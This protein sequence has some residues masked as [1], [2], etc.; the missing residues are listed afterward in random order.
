[1]ERPCIVSPSDAADESP[2]SGTASWI[3]RL[4]PVAV[5]ALGLAAFFLS[6]AHRLISFDAI[7]INYARLAEWV[8]DQPV[9]S[10]LAAVII[11]ATATAFSVPAA[12]L[13]SV[14]TGLVF[15]WIWGA[16]LV[17]L[18]AT[19]GATLLFLA[20]GHAFAD[21]FKARAGGWIDRMAK[22]FRDDAV[23]YMLFLRLAPVVPFALVNIVPAIL[24]VPLRIF[25]ATT[26][27]GIIPGVIAYV[28]AGQGLR[29][30]VAE[31]AA[32]CAD[33]VAPCGE[34]LSAGDLVT[35]EVLIAF[36]LLGFVS[37]LPVVLK[38]LRRHKI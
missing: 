13:F 9:I 32:S 4:W 16:V 7:A 10:S 35:P 21:F 8:A 2:R 36:A 30:I 20:A 33:G 6:G 28:F 37:L 1:M 19:L 5:I 25:V 22:G 27:I 14:A 17:T 12:W 29:S 38:R 26:A 34:P 18:G 31:R 24:G 11:Y 3:R 15:G 23:S